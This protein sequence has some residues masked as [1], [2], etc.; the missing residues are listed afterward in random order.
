M[1]AQKV[2]KSLM[3][4]T[5]LEG[6]LPKFTGDDDQEV[7]K[8]VE[9]FERVTNVVGCAEAEKFIYARRLLD[10]SAKIFLRS[11]KAENWVALKEE[12]C[13]EFHKEVGIK[14][15]L[16]QL[17][18]RKWKKGQESLHRYAL[19]MQELSK[20]APITQAEL[21]EFITEGMQDKSMA[22][23]VFLNVATVVDFKKMI[24]KYEKMVAERSQRQVK[25]TAVEK[26]F[27][28]VRCFNCQGIGHYSNVCKKPQRP[29]R[30]CFKCGRT[31][32]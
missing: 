32:E 27:P 7:T 4:F 14:E 20:G 25:V 31:S 1:E 15:I 21:V 24:P 11:A 9:E 17:G 30:A 3:A 23:L 18:N 8:W 26:V 29:M 19:V 10:G 13:V 28:E 5:E 16:R 22:A 12:L 6:A 2:N